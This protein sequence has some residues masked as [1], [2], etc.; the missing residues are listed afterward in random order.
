[1]ALV[2]FRQPLR[3]VV[4][5][6]GH[7]KSTKRDAFL[8]PFARPLRPLREIVSRKVRGGHAKSAK[9]DASLSDLSGKF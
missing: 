4:S 2:I 3:E 8:A 7:A 9:R 5:R 6:E 1:M